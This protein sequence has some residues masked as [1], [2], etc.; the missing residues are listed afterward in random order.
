[1]A[2]HKYALLSQGLEAYNERNNSQIILYK[3]IEWS[4]QRQSYTDMCQVTGR[5]GVGGKVI[6]EHCMAQL[7]GSGLSVRSNWY[8]KFTDEAAISVKPVLLAQYSAVD[9]TE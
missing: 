2:I 7:L 9:K 8:S 5:V 4:S 3:P 6:E 1:M